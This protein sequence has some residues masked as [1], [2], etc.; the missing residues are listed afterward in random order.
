[1]VSCLT[2]TARGAR[3]V[4]CRLAPTTTRTALPRHMLLTRRASGRS[5]SLAQDVAARTYR[6]DHVGR[7]ISVKGEGRTQ[8][9]PLPA[10][11]GRDPG[12]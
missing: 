7:V 8:H 5:A 9:R 3:M 4:R 6:G 1:M 11:E 10:F 2:D 12:E